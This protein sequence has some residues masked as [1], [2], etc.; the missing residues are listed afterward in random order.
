MI[1]ITDPAPASNA[2]AGAP[3]AGTSCTLPSGRTVTTRTEGG[4]E[5]L[6][7]RSAEGWTELHVDLTP[8]GPVLR[9]TGAEVELRCDHFE[10]DAREGIVERCGGDVQRSTEGNVKETVRGDHSTEARIVDV[11]ARRG[12][13]RIKAN[14]DVRLQGE[15]VKLNC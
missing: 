11:R 4:L 9:F 10:L 13:V 7:V 6:T 14:D 5:S 3:R 8:T 12:D 2:P 15:R 1:R